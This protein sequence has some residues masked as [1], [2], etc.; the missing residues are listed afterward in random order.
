MATTK[1]TRPTSRRPAA[2][3]KPKPRA[4]KPAAAAKNARGLPIPSAHT[5]GISAMV[6]GLGA[7]LAGAFAWVRSRAAHEGH[8]AP[9]LAPGADADRA[10][11]AFRPDMDA[12]MSAAERE[13]LRPATL[14]A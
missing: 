1:R 12:P 9:D 2:A 10:P 11:E 8:E 3:A 5:L 7:A 14:D 13:A 6:V 4:A